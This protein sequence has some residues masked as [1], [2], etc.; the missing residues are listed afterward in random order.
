LQ[1][2]PVPGTLD[3]SSFDQ[4]A[5]ELAE[6]GEEKALFDGRHLRWVDP[7]G[8]IGCWRLGLWLGI[9]KGS[10]QGSNSWKAPR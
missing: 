1:I 7:G 2:I 10:A 5:K 6:M 8:I 3:A 9:D 4:L